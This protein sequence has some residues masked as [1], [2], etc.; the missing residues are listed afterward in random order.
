MAMERKTFVVDAIDGNTRLDRW[1]QRILGSAPNSVYQKALRSGRV[2]LNGKKAE[3]NVRV[4]DG[5]IVEVRGDITNP[6]KAQSPR[7][8]QPMKLT[9]ELA[10]EAQALL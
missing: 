6:E 5:D 8:K 1:C 7:E 2:R 4:F 3:G 10:D 9:L